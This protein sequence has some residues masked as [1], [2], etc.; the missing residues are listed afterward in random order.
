MTA[1]V[2]RSRNEPKSVGTF[3]TEAEQARQSSPD[4]IGAEQIESPGEQDIFFS[5]Q[6][7]NLKFTGKSWARRAVGRRSRYNCLLI[8][9]GS[10]LRPPT[11][12][13]QESPR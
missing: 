6:T 10:S 4:L 7:G 5:A 1:K 12:V 8:Y 11:S 9:G 3:Q 13:G 2:L